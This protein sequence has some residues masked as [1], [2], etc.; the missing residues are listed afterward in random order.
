MATLEEHCDDCIK[1][2]GSPYKEVHIW[3]DEFSYGDGHKNPQ[4]RSARHHKAAFSQCLE[5]F[6]EKGISAMKIHLLKDYGGITKNSADCEDF[7]YRT[8]V[9]SL[10]KD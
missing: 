3:L 6:G 9:E 8:W 7:E 5:L 4:H 10:N 1:E 2:L